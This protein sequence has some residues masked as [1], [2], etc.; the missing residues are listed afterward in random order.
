MEVSFNP[1]KVKINPKDIDSIGDVN[2]H[3]VSSGNLYIPIT[4]L[5]KISKEDIILKISNVEKDT[6]DN[7][8]F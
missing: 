7:I 6:I 5:K 2:V 4:N 1:E 3:I 8:N